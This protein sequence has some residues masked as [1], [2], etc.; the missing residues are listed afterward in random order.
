VKPHADLSNLWSWSYGLAS[1][2]E[3]LRVD[4]LKA[5]FDRSNVAGAVEDGR[6]NDVKQHCERDDRCAQ[7]PAGRT[8]NSQAR[9]AIPVLIHTR[10]RRALIQLSFPVRVVH[11]AGT[12][13]NRFAGGAAMPK[14]HGKR[15]DVVNVTALPAGH[16]LL[17]PVVL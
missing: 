1:V 11:S 4:S 16:R 7:L 12:I 13:Q 3:R 8:G 5:G 6:I 15:T 10:P 2:C 17:L 14:R 9:V